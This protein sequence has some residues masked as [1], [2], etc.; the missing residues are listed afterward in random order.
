MEIAMQTAIFAGACALVGT[1]LGQALN[2]KTLHGS[3]LAQKRAE[4]FAK[5]LV[6]LYE[7]RKDTIKEN[8]EDPVIKGIALEKIYTS[9]NIVCFYLPESTRKEFKANFEKHIGFE[10]VF[11]GVITSK[12]L[13]YIYSELFES[14][15]KIQQIFEKTL[16]DNKPL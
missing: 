14:E 12:D 2:R 9:A 1:V 11:N 7:Y 5:F 3:W 8:E 4:V 13:K 16:K 15:V 10:P 6:D